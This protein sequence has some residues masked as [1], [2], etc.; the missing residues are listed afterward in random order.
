VLV[1]RDG[2]VRRERKNR[3]NLSGLR[4]DSRRGVID[5]VVDPS[6]V[7][8][9]PLLVV[10]VESA[11]M[12]RAL[13]ITWVILFVV[14]SAAAAAEP[15]RWALLVGVDD[16]VGFTDLRFSGRDAVALAE[17]LR[18]AGFDERRVFLL[19]DGAKDAAYRPSKP[20]IERQLKAVLN[21]A[22]P[23]D[24]VI[25]SFSG[26]GIHY[27]GQS[28]LCPTEAD[29]R[30]PAESML[31]VADVY[32]Q[33]EQCKAALKLLLVDACRNDPRPPGRKS[34]SPD[35][36]RKALGETFARPPAGIMVLQSC[37]E[38][39]I[40]W[41]DEQL[42]HGVFM[43]HVLKGLSGE[44]DGNK[45]GRVTLSE[46]YDY[47]SD[48]TKLFVANRFPGEIQIPAL[49]GNIRGVFEFPRTGPAKEITNSLGMKLVLIPAG[50][51]VMGSPEG[52]TDAEDDE[53]PQHR[54]RITKSFHLGQTE[55][56]QGQWQ[57][58]M[59]TTPW[60]GK[61]YVREGADYPATY[62]S[63]DDA[64]E[65]CR[66]LSGKE[67]KTYQLP[68]EAEWEYA[69]RAGTTTKYSFGDDDSRLGDYAWYDKNAYDVGQ[70]YAHAVGLKRPNLWGLMDM[71]GN[72]WEWCDDWY[73]AEFYQQSRVDDPKGV[74]SGSIRVNRGGGWSF[75]PAYCRS[76][77]RSRNTPDDR[78]YNLGFRAALVP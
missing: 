77:D 37:A 63:W 64:Q 58:V 48:E 34:A 67:N 39:Q 15:Q 55:V 62:V 21:L 26:H 41:E 75:T 74:T 65:F 3:I 1:G 69:C 50:E 53:K 71:H 7:G 52:D 17:A 18:G 42:Q 28:F 27:D 51:F 25:V 19:H 12:R 9:G 30:R 20:N 61:T 10:A 32:R 8:C 47:T 14:S 54:V 11:L 46:L 56:T 31:A 60:S 23:D 76:A 36:D 66:K 49:N 16:Y 38:D 44:A 22:G 33:F 73:E 6:S 57:A 68:T 70:K 45:N 5:S 29:D 35:V 13:A 72:V 4:I 78:R 59:R 24:L 40:S 43:H 2:H